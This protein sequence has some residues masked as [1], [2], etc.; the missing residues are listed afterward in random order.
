MRELCHTLQR[1]YN[2]PVDIEFTANFFAK[3][4]Y[5]VNLVQCRPL[6]VVAGSATALRRTP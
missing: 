5:R 2:Y 1:A 6:Q 3:D 4:Q